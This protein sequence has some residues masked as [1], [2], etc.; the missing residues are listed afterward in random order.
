MGAWPAPLLW[1]LTTACL[2]VPP[3]AATTHVPVASTPV[4]PSATTT[5]VP[6]AS[7]PAPSSATTTVASAPPAATTTLLAGVESTT[8]NLVASTAEPS[9][10]PS[11]KKPTQT[12]PT[13][14]D[15]TV[16]ASGSTATSEAPTGLTATSTS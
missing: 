12:L 2:T 1:S 4:P 10:G 16:L 9:A 5:Q 7:T 14:T 8:A 3:S 6:V 15:V 13:T 11:T